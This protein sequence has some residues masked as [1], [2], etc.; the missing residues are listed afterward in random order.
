M[1]A[2]IAELTGSELDPTTLATA[3]QNLEFTCDPIAASLGASAAHAEELG[4]LE[5]TDLDGIYDLTLLN[6]VLTDA[7][8]EEIPQP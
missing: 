5:P 3:W 8:M 1:A 7:G 4:L 2:A 6:Q